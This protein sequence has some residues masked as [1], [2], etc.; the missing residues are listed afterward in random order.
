MKAQAMMALILQVI[1]G[2]ISASWVLV[3][4]ATLVGALGLIILNGMRTDIKSMISRQNEAEQKITRNTERT[5]YAHE[6]IDEMKLSMTP[7]QP[8]R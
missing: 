6:R 7:N 5:E 4:L 2:T 3:I 8:K 1:N